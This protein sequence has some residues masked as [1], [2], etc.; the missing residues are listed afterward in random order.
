MSVGVEAVTKAKEL[1]SLA[2]Q[3]LYQFNWI[4]IQS[5]TLILFQYEKLFQYVLLSNIIGQVSLV[6]PVVEFLHGF[7]TLVL[8]Y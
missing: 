5:V 4:V 8:Y 2:Y 3:K 7:L 6:Q 1:H